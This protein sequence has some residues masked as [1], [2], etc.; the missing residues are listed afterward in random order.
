MNTLVIWKPVIILGLVL[1]FLFSDFAFSADVV[2]LAKT[3]TSWNGG[4][5]SYPTGDAEVTAVKIRLDAGESTEW[6]CHPVPAFAYMLKGH[7]EVVTQSGQSHLF[8]KGDVID[9]VM[10]SWH[11]GK[12]VKG[13]AE[14]VAFYAGAVGVPN[15]KLQSSGDSCSPD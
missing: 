9:E 1:L 11:Q 13:P 6:H 7:I 8:D 3:S 2:V 15:T 14:L 12:A 4:D 5:F 10:N